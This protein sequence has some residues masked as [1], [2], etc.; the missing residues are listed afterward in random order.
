MYSL[1]SLKKEMRKM[2]S[3]IQLR[4]SGFVKTKM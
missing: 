1:T 4:E 3:K 2:P